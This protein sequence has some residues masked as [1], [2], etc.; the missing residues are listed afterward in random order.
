[1]ARTLASLLTVP[2]LVGVVVGTTWAVHRFHKPGQL[3]VVTAQAMDMSAMR[4]PTGAA[5]V[6]LASVRRGRLDDATTYTGSI[7]AFNEQD[8][9]A[10][11]AGT[12]TALSV[13][14]GDTVR[15]GQVVA[16]LDSAELGAKTD[17]AAAQARQASLTAQTA[18]VYQD[19]HHQATLDQASAQEDAAGQA[20]TEAQGEAQAAQDAVTEARAGVQSAQANAEYWKTEIVREQQLTEAGAASRQEYE[21]EQAQAQAAFAALAQARSKVRQAQATV[22][23]AHA[24]VAQMQRQAQAARAGRRMVQA[25]L[26]VAAGQVDQATAGASAAQ[27]A[28]REASVVQGYTRLVSPADGIVTERPVAPGMLVQPGTTLL[29]V[30]EISRVR[31]QAHVAAADLAGIAP[32]TPLQVT[33]QGGGA[34]PIAAKVTSVFPSGDDR[35]RTA[36]VEA[37]V[38]NPGGRLRPGAFVTVRLARPGTS[39]KVLVPAAS[40][41]TEGGGAFVW[42]ASGGAASASP[43]TYQCEK[44]HMIYSAADARKDHYRDPMDG[45]TLRPVLTAASGVLAGGLTVRRV[46]LQTG[47]SDG[48]WTEVVGGN[49]PQGSRI[50][51]HGQAGLVEGGTVVATAWGA[52]GPRTLPTALSAAHGKTLYRCDK[53]GMTYSEA[54]ARRNH[55]VDPM[56]G[57][58]LTPVPPAPSGSMPG[59]ASGSMPGMKM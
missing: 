21:S 55:F 7:L 39:D 32:G 59:G 46:A 53:C 8:I 4:P 26:V 56:D 11:V 23:A 43:A 49:I 36:V 1:M 5:P 48:T 6:A 31:V 19:L 14:P 34:R 30:A 57:G 3:D 22:G 28:A 16:Q 18:R 15:V 9:S 33:A 13:Y 2:V 12:V 17:Q 35:T 37:V 42:L 50:V 44:C 40:I 10:R 27:A 52:D 58:K 25:D 54:D 41:V 38:A 20:V 29:K 47:A 24:K 51:T 45:G